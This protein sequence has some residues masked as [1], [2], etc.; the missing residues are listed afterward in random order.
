MK[1]FSLTLTT[2]KVNKYYLINNENIRQ[3]SMFCL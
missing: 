3:L 1:L 2:G